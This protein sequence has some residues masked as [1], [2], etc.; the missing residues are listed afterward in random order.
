M[1][2]Y[3]PYCGER[4]AEK[5]GAC[6]INYAPTTSHHGKTR[7]RCRVCSAVSEP[8]CKDSTD[9]VLCKPGKTKQERTGQPWGNKEARLSDIKPR[10]VDFDAFR[11]NMD[12]LLMDSLF[13]TPKS[14]PLHYIMP[15][16]G[17]AWRSLYSSR[18]D[19]FDSL[20]GLPRCECE[21]PLPRK[22]DAR[23]PVR[24]ENCLMFMTPEQVKRFEADMKR[25]EV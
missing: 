20:F 13:G 4:L 22:Q 15:R 17:N 14:K 21:A 12:R 7:Y 8:W 1:K 2:R 5:G 24:C 11:R 18:N 6:W 16:G 19:K 3:C 23:D 10:K 9:M 25:F